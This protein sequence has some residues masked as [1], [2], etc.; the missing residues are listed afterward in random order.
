MYLSRNAA[1][2]FATFCFACGPGERVSIQTGEATSR[3]RLE[4]GQT[5]T[6]SFGL[7]TLTGTVVTTGVGLSLLAT[8]EAPVSR[9]ITLQATDVVWQDDRVYA[10]YNVRG[11]EYLG[12]LQVI[13]V[14]D[15]N[16]PSVIAEAI[17]PAT[18]LAHLV[19]SGGHILAAGEDASLGGT[20]EAFRF[21]N[22]ALIYEGDVQVGSYAATYLALDGY[23][24]YLSTG[25]TGGVVQLDLSGGQPRIVRNVA[26]NDAR[27]VE[28]IGADL[29]AVAGNPGRLVKYHEFTNPSATTESTITVLG[30]SVG[31]PT[32]ATR[33]EGTLYLSSNEAGLLVID[34]WTLAQ[35]GQ[36]PTTG[37]ANGP[38]LALDGRLLF[39]ANGESGLVLADVT[40]PRTPLE[41]ASL[42]VAG[43]RGSANATAISGDHLALADG[44]GGV[45]IIDYQRQ[46]V[47]PPSDCDGDGTPDGM[48]ADDDDDGVLDADDSAPCDP[49]L[50]CGGG[51]IDHVSR[52][53]GDF[54]NLPCDHP[55]V[56]GPIT[57]VVRGHQP[58]DY[59]WFS[60]RYYVFSIE[61]LSL[62]MPYS[63]NYFP[64]NTGLCGDPYY[65]AAHWHTTAIA[66]E[67][68][69]Y[70]FELGTDDD[71]W[72]YI[73]GKLVLDLGGI[74]AL[75]RQGVDV[76]LTTGPHRIDI[77]FAE[78]HRVQSGLEF[79]VSRMP[80]PTARLDL[81]QHVCLDPAADIDGDGISNG[82][83]LAPL[84]RP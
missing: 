45:K 71:G 65:F 53:V 30:A 24:A 74:H 14:S 83:D 69:V 46:A 55:D 10:S 5:Q 27:W 82:L 40:D 19:V 58:S 9:G 77:W 63:A 50:A 62:M 7:R 56:E 38:S 41:V 78:R 52:F 13:D 3:T 51:Q 2:L 37:T 54:Y 16:S 36:L 73:D 26:L 17:Y 68:G 12:A 42:D 80:S 35:I 22:G 29:I 59:D 48:D 75:Q 31:A 39:L 49:S 64:V 25:D 32:W 47:T 76:N 8:I 23:R 70:R 67:A 81:I 28:P 79:T 34:L 6:A 20:L 60:P 11:E 1:A 84:S 61:R 4:M 44:L 15:V 43:D 57:G 66:T 18:D 72:L 33:R 21:E